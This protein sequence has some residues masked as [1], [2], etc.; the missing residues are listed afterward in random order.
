MYDSGIPYGGPGY[1]KVGL[2]VVFETPVF[3]KTLRIYPRSF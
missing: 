1:G 3:A 2:P